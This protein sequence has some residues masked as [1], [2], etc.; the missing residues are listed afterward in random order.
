VQELTIRRT[1]IEALQSEA[2]QG[3]HHLSSSA[4]FLKAVIISEFLKSSFCNKKLPE[5][6]V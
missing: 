3:P 2:L 1:P 5:S 6:R 4:R